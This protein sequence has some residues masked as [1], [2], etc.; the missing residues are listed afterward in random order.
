M[1]FLLEA[2]QQQTDMEDSIFS[3]RI[4][5]ITDFIKNESCKNKSMEI[6]GFI[7]Y[8]EYDKKYIA[9]I[10][11]NTA[12]DPKNFFSINPIRYLYFKQDFNII[13]IFHSHIIGDEMPSEFDIKMSENCCVPFMIFSIN[14]NKFYFYEP[15][16]KEY[17]VKVVSRFKEKIK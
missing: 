8:S 2:S 9:K 17:D 15:Q 5:A 3:S 10:E 7:G 1:D 4:L 16:N 12:S 6:C 14:S 11:K 13:A